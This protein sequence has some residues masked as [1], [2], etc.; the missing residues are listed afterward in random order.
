[1]IDS[2]ISAPKNAMRAS[3]QIIELQVNAFRIKAN[4]YN[5]NLII[6]SLSP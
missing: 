5:S 4:N 2:Y 3:P 6:I 1:M